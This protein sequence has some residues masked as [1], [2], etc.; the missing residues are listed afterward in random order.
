MSDELDDFI[1]YCKYGAEQKE[2]SMSV[3]II[4]P[5]FNGWN[6]THKRMMELHTHISNPVEIILVDDCSTD[7]VSGAMGFWKTQNRHRVRCIKT[8]KNLGFGGAMNFGCKRATESVLVLLSN[9]VQISGDFVPAILDKID[10]KCLIGNTFRNYDTGWNVLN[11]NGKDKMFPYL[12]GY[13]LA[14]NQKA[15]KDLGG[16]DPIFAPYDVEDMDISTTAL[17]KGYKLIPLNL[18]MLMHLSGQTI[19]KVNPNRETITKRNQKRFIGKW[20]KILKD[21]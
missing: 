7:D 2:F 16:F 5:F 11:I 1:E 13:L 3:S 14:C 20:S 18:R 10:D 15:W 4:I 12:E 9:D 21:E 19:R 6:L 8:P 17:H